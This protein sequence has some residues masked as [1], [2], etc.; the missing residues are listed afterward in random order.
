[1]KKH[2]LIIL[3]KNIEEKNLIAEENEIKKLNYPFV[4]VIGREPNDDKEIGS[5]IEWF[6]FNWY[7]SQFWNSSY[8]LIGDIIGLRD[9]NNSPGSVLKKKFEEKSSSFIAYADFSYKSI[10][11]TKAN[12]GIR[13]ELEESKLKEHIKALF[14]HDFVRDKVQLIVFN[15]IKDGGFTKEIIDYAEKNCPKSY[16][17]VDY[18]CRMDGKTNRLMQ[19]DELKEVHQEIKNIYDKWESSK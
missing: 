16:A 17:H 5:H 18:V 6:N 19:I 3:Y 1:M 11:F 13:S 10:K 9:K 14:E 15:G 8:G 2:P 7:Q 12:K 4:L